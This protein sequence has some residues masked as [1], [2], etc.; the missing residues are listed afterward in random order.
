MIMES[1]NIFFGDKQEALSEY[2]RVTRPGGYVG[3]TETTWLGPPS[4]R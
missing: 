4:P 1:V 3:M 2:V